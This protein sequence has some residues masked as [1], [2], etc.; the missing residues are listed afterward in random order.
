M[1]AGKKVPPTGL[2]WSANAPPPKDV[3]RTLA[4]VDRKGDAAGSGYRAFLRK[5]EL[6]EAPTSE[7]NPLAYLWWQFR[8]FRDDRAWKS[9]TDRIRAMLGMPVPAQQRVG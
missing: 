5:K 4:K 9:L 8:T 3:D 1:K 7:K 2:W 6:L